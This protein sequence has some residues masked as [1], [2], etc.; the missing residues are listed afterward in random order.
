MSRYLLLIVTS[1][2]I[3]SCGS[4]CEELMWFRDSDGDGFGDPNVMEF[5][6]DPI[7]GFV[8][9]SVD[10]DD[11]CSIRDWR[12]FYQDRDSDGLGGRLSKTF[13][14][15][16]PDMNN[17]VANG[18]DLDDSV[19]SGPDE[20]VNIVIDFLEGFEITDTSILSVLVPGLP[21]DD[22]FIQHSTLYADG[23]D[24]YLPLFR[25]F[26]KQNEI[27]TFNVFTD[28]DHVIAHIL[29]GGRWNNR[30]PQIALEVFR[31]EDGSIAEHWDNIEDIV[32]ED[33]TPQIIET[34]PSDVGANEILVRNMIS[35]VFVND[36]PTNVELYFSPNFVDHSSRSLSFEALMSAENNPR[37]DDIELL[38]GSD[39]LILAG[40]QGA[41][42]ELNNIET[43]F[44]LYVINDGLIT[45]RWQT[46][47]SLTDAFLH[48]NGKW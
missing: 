16:N 9:N 40:V 19:L 42:D 18:Y 32:S 24:G 4:D 43:Y 17:L 34:A 31:I 27:L 6:C 37:Y 13:D 29:Y 39:N 3:I 44:D 2:L 1:F 46:I 14:C 25:Q 8:S 38:F 28:D 47:Q 30:V 20:L 26:N 12:I 7:D 15:S 35:D 33:Q 21:E 48:M 23:I 45:E 22:G 36:D 41:P 11:N 10:D 5:G